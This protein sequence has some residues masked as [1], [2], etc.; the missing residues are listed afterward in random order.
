LLASLKGQQVFGRFDYDVSDGVHAYVQVGG[1]VKKNSELFGLSD[2]EQG[3][4]EPRTP[5]SRQPTGRRWPA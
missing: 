4:A 3:H 2:P 5:S 1:N